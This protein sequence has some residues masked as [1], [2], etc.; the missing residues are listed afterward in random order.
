MSIIRINKREHPYAQVDKRVLDDRRLSWRSKGI[1]VYL[2]AKPDGW[3]V[4]VQDI[5][6]K[7]KEGRN[8]VQACLDELQKHGYAQLVSIKGA[9]NTFVG[10]EWQVNEEPIGGFLD[11]TE[12]PKTNA[13]KAR[14]SVS[15][16]VNSNNKDSLTENQSNNEGV[17]TPPPAEN[18]NNLEEEKSKRGLVPPPPAESAA[19]DP[20]HMVTEIRPESP[21]T[22]LVVPF[23]IAPRV[24]TVDD[25]EEI[26]MAWA[27]TP[28]GRESVRKWYAEA[29]RNCTANDV[30]EMVAKFAGVYLTIG[31]EGKRQRMAQDPLQ[32]FKYTFKVFLKNEKAYSRQ[33]GASAQHP[34]PSPVP[35]NIRRL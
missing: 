23:T 8:A 26:I 2:L 9:G 33:P 15:R 1:L 30:K 11:T 24:D 21:S 27:T 31:D 17:N 28:I 14:K 35:A 13:P 19:P 29:A 6:S 10:K 5:W 22:R 16:G 34:V 3:T 7:G 12:R 32:F 4:R 25:A 20:T 18:F